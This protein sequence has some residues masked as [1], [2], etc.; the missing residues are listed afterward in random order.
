MPR[1]S[2]DSAVERRADEHA[3]SLEA[4]PEHEKQQ[5][6]GAVHFGDPLAA[7]VRRA[8]W[9]ADAGEKTRQQFS[10]SLPESL[11]R[12]RHYG[13]IADQRGQLRVGQRLA[14]GSEAQQARMVGVR[15]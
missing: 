4:A 6:D 1:G 5:P 9:S 12:D 3:G 15:Y 10:V 13:R 2:G 14:A 8:R 7:I 11:A